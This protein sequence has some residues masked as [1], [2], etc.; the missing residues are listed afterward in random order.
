MKV[1][2]TADLHYR[3]H[4]FRWLI[5]RRADYDLI[6]VAGDLLD[7]F[8]NEPRTDQA[9]KVS[10]W[11]RE[12]AKVSWVAISSG[13]HD[14][15]GHQI[16]TDRAPVYQWFDALRS[17]PKIVTDGVTRVIDD[18]IVTTV[19]YHC[20]REQKSIWLE[21]GATIRRQ[22]VKRW[23]V[24]HHV[25]PSTDPV[26]SSAEEAEAA[27][28]LMTYRPDFF[29]AGHTHAYPYLAGNSWA[30]KI[31]GVSVLVPG[32]LL[33]APFPNHVVLDTESGQA[34]WKTSS[35]A[36]IPEDGLYDHLVLKIK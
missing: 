7:M 8:D 20:S 18:L 1:L 15:A 33:R 35:R 27:A 36:W 10:R 2:I 12:L 14:N 25:P 28:L 19:P 23:L 13:N 30:Q 22:G 29:V 5:E 34:D 32:Q 6:C 31:N 3:E 16:T 4:W 21:R 17:E 11:I 26:A 24:L 9:W